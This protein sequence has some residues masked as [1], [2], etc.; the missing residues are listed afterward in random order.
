MTFSDLQFQ[1]LPRVITGVDISDNSFSSLNTTTSYTAD[2]VTVSF[3]GMSIMPNG[4]YMKVALETT[5]LAGDFLMNTEG[6]GAASNNA[7][8]ALLGYTVTTDTLANITPMS[9]NDLLAFDVIW[10]NPGNGIPYATLQAAVADGG[11][12][13]QYAAAGGVLVLCVAGTAGNQNDIAPGGVDALLVDDVN[14]TPH[15]A[16]TFTTPAHPYLTGTGYGGTA[17]VTTD[18]DG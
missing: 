6:D 8:A 4:G 15:N 9:V 11:S 14:V 3:T 7:K 13:E 2:S 12:L 16:E 17:L 18:F 5:A 10:F 1:D